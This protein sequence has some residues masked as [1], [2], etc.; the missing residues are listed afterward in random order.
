[1]WGV[2]FGL[3]WLEPPSGT[4]RPT[5]AGM[6][7]TVSH[8]GASSMRIAPH[9]TI[10]LLGVSSLS[11]SPGVATAANSVP[12]DPLTGSGVVSRTANTYSSLMSSAQPTALVNESN[13]GLPANAAAPT[14]TF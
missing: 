2:G 14:D 7:R 3:G 5:A 4:N 10:V 1:M 11:C 8:K 13:F 12:G 6:G 9:L